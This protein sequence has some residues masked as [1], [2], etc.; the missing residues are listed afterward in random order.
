[1]FKGFVDRGDP[2]GWSTGSSKAIA[3]TGRRD[4][5]R[6]GGVSELLKIMVRLTKGGRAIELLKGVELP[7]AN[8]LESSGLTT[9]DA[10]NT[11]GEV[12]P[13]PLVKKLVASV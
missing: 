9:A 10:G 4:L 12:A 11:G 8:S 5:S 3:K 1:M 6:V 2:H 7:K 13:T